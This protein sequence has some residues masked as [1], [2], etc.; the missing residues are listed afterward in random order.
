MTWA[1]ISREHQ[2]G[3]LWVPVLPLRKLPQGHTVRL[4]DS[5]VHILTYQAALL[6]QQDFRSQMGPQ[7]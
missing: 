7:Q 1:L 2:L 5:G 4:S 3:Q 6:Y